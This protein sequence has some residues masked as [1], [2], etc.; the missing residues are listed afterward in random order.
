MDANL[1]MSLQQDPAVRPHKITGEK[2]RQWAAGFV[3]EAMR[4]Q[5]YGQSFCNRFG[6]R[7][8]ILFYERDLARA[9]AYIR[10]N[11]V[12]DATSDTAP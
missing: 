9:D 7:D 12:T 10:R 11:Y 8:N 3:F 4:D 6:I 1:I 5:R 2:Y